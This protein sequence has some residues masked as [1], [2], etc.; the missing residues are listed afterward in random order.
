MLRFL[1]GRKTYLCG[2]GW[3][4]WGLYLIIVVEPPQTE[5]G[6]KKILE[7]LSLIF[8]RASVA[9]ATPSVLS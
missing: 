4:L 2:I 5:E 7:G 9:K 6:L 8:L 3:V 1:R